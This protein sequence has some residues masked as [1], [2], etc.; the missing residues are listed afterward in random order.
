[1]VTSVQR[2]ICDACQSEYRTQKAAVFCEASPSLPPCCVRVGDLVHIHE[3]VYDP[4]PDE[5]I[6]ILLIPTHDVLDLADW[7]ETE[8]TEDLDA[9]IASKPDL[10]CHQWGVRV[11]HEH[12]TS[13]EDV[14]TDTVPLSYVY[15]N[16]T[17]L[18]VL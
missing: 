16:N 7:D 8:D 18:E 15:V 4:Q 5:I 2:F 14:Y 12:H 1:M 9:F 11:H 10:V 3:E 13:N 6:E 17:L